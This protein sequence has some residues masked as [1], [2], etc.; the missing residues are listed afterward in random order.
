MKFL[1]LLIFLM[2]VMAH[3]QLSNADVYRLVTS[4]CRFYSG[5]PLSDLIDPVGEQID[6]P[7]LASPM[8]RAAYFRTLKAGLVSMDYFSSDQ[9]I[10]AIQNSPALEPALQACYGNDNRAKVGFVFL[11]DDVQNH[12][13]ADAALITIGSFFAAEQFVVRLVA[14]VPFVTRL[15]SVATEMGAAKWITRYLVA[16]V[17]YL[18]SRA[19]YEWIQYERGIYLKRKIDISQLDSKPDVAKQEQ[20]LQQANQALDAMKAQA[21]HDLENQI[22]TLQADLPKIQSPSQRARFQDLIRR[23]QAS[24]TELKAA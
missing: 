17:A 7:L 8:G 16:E 24:L 15:A 19:L 9:T 12:A 22:R 11:M 21:V 14:R 20:E 10:N 4:S 18:S 6:N 23:S 1:A 13:K 3:A 5:E 2:P